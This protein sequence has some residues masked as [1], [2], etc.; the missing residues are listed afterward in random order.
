MRKGHGWREAGRRSFG[1]HATPGGDRDV[2]SLR[3]AAARS[4]EHRARY[5]GKPQRARWTVRPR[6]G[7]GRLHSEG[8]TR[9]PR[10]GVGGQCSSSSSHQVKHGGR[11]TAPSLQASGDP[12]A[13]SGGR[14]RRGSH[15][16]GPCER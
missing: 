15:M 3:G 11:Q 1:Q 2:A 13:G 7:S 9:R 10:G 4:R 5:N 6:A 14:R 16:R 8:V 12:A